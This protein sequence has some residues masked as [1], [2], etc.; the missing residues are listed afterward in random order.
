[1]SEESSTHFDIRSLQNLIETLALDIIVL[2][3]NNKIC[4]MQKEIQ[5]LNLFKIRDT[6]N[7]FDEKNSFSEKYIFVGNEKITVK[8]AETDQYRLVLLDNNHSKI[9]SDQL[10]I[11]NHISDEVYKPSNDLI[12]LV[13]ELDSYLKIMLPSNNIKNKDVHKLLEKIN[14]KKREIELN[15][16]ENLFL[17]ETYNQLIITDDVRINPSELIQSVA[18]EFS[19]NLSFFVQ[20]DEN[21]GV[22]YGSKNWLIAAI[23]TLIHDC[24]KET[25]TD[26]ILLN[27]RQN[28]KEAI[29][30]IE[31]CG[32][33]IPKN[34]KKLILKNKAKSKEDDVIDK[35]L[36]RKV[37]ESNGGNF[38]ITKDADY[39]KI[40]LAI[41]TG[42]PNIIRTST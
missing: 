22:I 20:K 27:I 34:F 9:K 17:I 25:H 1:M 6:L 21:L 14:S 8:I 28:S 16:L 41:P 35:D 3:K 38:K 11:K 24:I 13:N 2:D 30:I 18:L 10:N 37:I 40:I 15:Y 32:S 7:I 23:K 26:K 31:N 39:F 36:S 12:T 4:F 42:A 29:L 33:I 19:K 5:S